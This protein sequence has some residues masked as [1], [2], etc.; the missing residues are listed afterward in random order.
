[1]MKSI[2]ITQ[3]QFNK[4]TSATIDEYVAKMKKVAADKGE[5]YSGLAE[6][7][8]R[9]TLTIVLGLLEANLFGKR[10]DRDE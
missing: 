9:L 8:D 7:G 10:G 2:L 1:M 6:F 3:E 4:M 5:R